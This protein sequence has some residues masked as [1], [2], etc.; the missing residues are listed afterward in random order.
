MSIF[1]LNLLVESFAGSLV[2]KFVAEGFAGNFS[3]NCWA[4]NCARCL[5]DNW[6]GF[7]GGGLASNLVGVVW[8]EWLKPGTN[9]PGADA[10]PA[11][12]FGFLSP[13]TTGRRKKSEKLDTKINQIIVYSLPFLSG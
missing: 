12:P 3:G 1:L 7:K 9:E 5:A 11:T 10:A 4:G 13:V 2:G 8:E 6:V